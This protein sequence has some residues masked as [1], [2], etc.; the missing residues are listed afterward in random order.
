MSDDR[1][2]P[3]WLTPVNE[4]LA[5]EP[6]WDVPSPPVTPEEGRELLRRINAPGGAQ[7]LLNASEREFISSEPAVRDKEHVERLHQALE[8]DG[9]D[10]LYVRGI[11]AGLAY[12][13]GRTPAPLTG[14]HPRELPRC[15]D[16]REEAALGNESLQGA[17]DEPFPHP[18]DYVV[19][20]EA[21]CLWLICHT[22]M[23]P[24]ELDT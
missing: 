4:L 1:P 11:R 10:G 20:V 17:L 8:Q 3:A 12:A 15:A 21:T 9:E 6:T 13:E 19:G 14:Y 2:T 16:L 24:I 7:L 22:D 5:N 18:Q 23:P